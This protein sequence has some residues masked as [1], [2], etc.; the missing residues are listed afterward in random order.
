M[1][2]SEHLLWSKYAP[3]Q[4]GPRSISCFVGCSI[5]YE[6]D[7]ADTICHHILLYIDK[8]ISPMMHFILLYHANSTTIE[9]IRGFWFWL[10]AQSNCASRHKSIVPTVFWWRIVC[11]CVTWWWSSAG[12][13]MSSVCSKQYV[14]PACGIRAQR[15]LQYRQ[16]SSLV[17]NECGYVGTIWSARHVFLGQARVVCWNSTSPLTTP[18]DPTCFS[19]IPC[20][21]TRQDA[22]R[23]VKPWDFSDGSEFK[24]RPSLEQSLNR[25][26]L[27]QG[28]GICTDHHVALSAVGSKRHTKDLAYAKAEDIS[29]VHLLNPAARWHRA[30]DANLEKIS[31][32]HN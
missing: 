24:L 19:C 22:R 10:C 6:T 30:I 28:G 16:K 27:L 3:E 15:L 17:P 23:E 1:T 11:S 2:L 7:Q 13:R 5:V 18:K 20:R 4:Q 12:K 32:C 25:A 9:L 8:C 29:F 14:Q 31:W 21:I 26:W